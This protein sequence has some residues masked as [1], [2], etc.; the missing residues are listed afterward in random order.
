MTNRWRRALAAPSGLFLLAVLAAG[1]AAPLLPLAD[2]TAIDISSKFLPPSLEHPFG[3]DLLGRDMLSRMIWGIRTTFVTALLTMIV[4]AGVGMI[5]GGAAAAARGRVDALIMRFC[6]VWMSFPSE[7]LILTLVGMMGPGLENV[8]I[9]CLLAKWPWYARM[10]R[11][12]ILHLNSAGFVQFARVTG[13]SNMKVLFGHLV[14][15]AAGECFVLG[16]IDTGSVV[17][18]ISA[19]S[20]LGLGAQ[21][22]MPEWGGRE[23]RDDALSGTDVRARPRDPARGG[24]AQLPRRR[25]SRRLRREE[26]RMT[27]A[28]DVIL[29][30]AGLRVR[31][32]RDREILHGLDLDVRRGECL[33]LV[34]ESGAGKS[35]T[36]R[37]LAGLLPHGFTVS[38]TMDF[39]GRT[40][41]APGAFAAVRGRRILYM[42]QQAMTAFDPLVRIGVQLGETASTAGLSGSKADE[43]VS[44][45]LRAVGLDPARILR[46]FP[47][48]LSG[49]MLQRVMTACVLILRPDVILADEPTSALDVVNVRAVLASL[50][51]VRRTTGSALVLVTHDLGLAAGLADRFVILMSGG[52]VEKGGRE[53]FERPSHPYTQRLALAWRR[54]NAV[55]QESLAAGPAPAAE[56]PQRAPEAEPVL[57]IEGVTKYYASGSFLRRSVHEVLRGV[58]LEVRRGEVVGLIGGSGE[59]KSTLSRLILGLEAPTAGRILVRGADRSELCS[60]EASVVFQNYLDSA[61]PVWTVGD[62][63]EEPVRLAGGRVDVRDLLRHVGL[64]AEYAS[65]RPHQLSG[66]ELQ[67]VA[68]ARAMGGGPSLVVFDE[69]LSS[70]D[71]SVQDEIMELLAELKPDH[72]GWLFI[73]HDLKAVARLC[74][75]VAVL[76]E[77]RIVEVMDAARMGS[78]SSEA[79]R[80]FV[81]AAAAALPRA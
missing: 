18:M 46:A 80:R 21:P 60:G 76:S 49:G 22:P 56:E 62:V 34:G 3:T 41:C 78:P 27:D 52:I 61:D 73:S 4:T 57:R 19:L 68:I 63:I 77:G 42:A 45:A 74:D 15:N 39:E 2:P 69:A 6:D 70:L 47:C 23:E 58:N 67:R 36:L 54:A 50:Q 53:I 30:V 51:E 43:A 31:D 1:L 11:G 16:T 65:R 32:S 26:D 71:A 12:L 64:P 20:F 40:L 48:E 33:A 44:R 8:L 14:P 72:A 79:G 75:R 5:A 25:A 17:L 81:E 24:G 66:G 10:M 59:G 37:A 7:V 35:L 55:L 38:G 9:A 28:D 29:S 13:A